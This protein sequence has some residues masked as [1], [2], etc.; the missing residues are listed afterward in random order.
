LAARA[1]EAGSG[2]A[3]SA[4]G[5]GSV[6]AAQE[7]WAAQQRGEAGAR[8]TSLSHVPAQQGGWP[9]QPLRAPA[10]PQPGAQPAGAHQ[11]HQFNYGAPGTAGPGGGP[12]GG[13]PGPNQW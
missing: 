8:P 5:A 3:S 12:G 7:R 13:Q 4:R 2:A 6:A 10:P 11:P 9:Q 1:V